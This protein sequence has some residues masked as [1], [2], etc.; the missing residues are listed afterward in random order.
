MSHTYQ[1][2][3]L[4]LYF[5]LFSP[6]STFE[7]TLWESLIILRCFFLLN[8]VCVTLQELSSAL[9]DRAPLSAITTSLP[10]CHV[11][12]RIF[13]TPLYFSVTDRVSQ[14]YTWDSL[15]A[16]PYV[17]IFLFH[18]EGLTWRMKMPTHT[19]NLLCFYSQHFGS[20]LAIHHLHP[21]TAGLCPIG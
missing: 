18:S 16:L 1:L 12:H 15:I 8:K 19:S 10:L 9:L 21:S 4:N 3:V 2:L 17:D 7:S 6:L 5:L 13:K 20:H 14:G 11:R